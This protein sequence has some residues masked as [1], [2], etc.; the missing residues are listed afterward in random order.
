MTRVVVT[1]ETRTWETRPADPSDSWDNGDTAGEVTNVVAFMERAEAHYYGESHGKDLGDVEIGDTVYA[2]VADYESGCT[3]GRDGGH[4]TVLDFFTD[5]AEA[6]ALAAA[7]LKPDGQVERWAGH[8]V[9]QFDYSFTH[10]G[11]SYYRSWVG[12]FESLNSLDVWECRIKGV[13]KDPWSDDP[14]PGFRTGH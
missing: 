11:Q 5:P 9:D 14:Q 1:A 12:Y 4:A 8:M 2:V 10:N 6:K 13:A 7:A 3:F